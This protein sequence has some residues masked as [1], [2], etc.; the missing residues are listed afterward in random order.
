MRVILLTYLHRR[1]LRTRPI[2][3]S[4]VIHQPCLFTAILLVAR[5]PLLLLTPFLSLA[6]SL[7]SPLLKPIVL[8]A[9]NAGIGSG[10]VDE[11][12]VPHTDLFP[13]SIAA[14][15]QIPDEQTPFCGGVVS[16]HGDSAI[17]QR[18]AYRRFSDAP[19][20]PA[21]HPVQWPALMLI[22]SSPQQEARTVPT[23]STPRP[24]KPGARNP[25]LGSTAQAPIGLMCCGVW[26][27][28]YNVLSGSVPR[29]SCADY[30]G[31]KYSQRLECSSISTG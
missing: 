30:I 23:T 11:G 2:D 21:Q 4:R 26:L 29:R 10:V 19:V 14:R 18:P 6:S 8:I 16:T 27:T 25:S 5:S 7:K 17:Q 20:S 22:P 1:G 28:D 12:V 9:S 24:Q 15:R 3:A 31:P 13:S